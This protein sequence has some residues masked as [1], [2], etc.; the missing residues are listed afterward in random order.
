[1]TKVSDA[2]TADG[3]TGW[4]KIFEDTWSAVAGASTGSDDDWGTKD[5]N[6]CCGKMAVMI[7]SDIP[8]GDYLLRAEVI[9]LHVAGQLDGAQFYMSCCMLDALAWHLVIHADNPSD[10]ITVTGGG[11][12]SPETVLLP[13]AYS[14]TDPGILI[15]IYQSMTTYD[16]PGPTVYS[17]GTTKSAGAPCSGIETVTT[18]GI[19]YTGGGGAATSVTGNTG[20]GTLAPTTTVTKDTTSASVTT[21]STKTTTSSTA[22]TS[23]QGTTGCTVAKYGQCGGQGWTGCGTCA[24]SAFLIGWSGIWYL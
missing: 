15:D 9:A 3:S 19:A 14:A 10:Q 4:F 11:T 13:G 23:S 22:A 5:L 1:M 16:V 2:T 12:A 6:A 8:A 20:S 17:G 21:L 24:V 7:P 18:T